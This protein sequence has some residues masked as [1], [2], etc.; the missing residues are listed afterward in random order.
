M[1]EP[2]RAVLP[3][4]NADHRHVSAPASFHQAPQGVARILHG[5]WL[6]ALIVRREEEG[7][8]AQR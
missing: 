3:E 6:V 7:D 8:A 2:T 1:P 4:L 5:V